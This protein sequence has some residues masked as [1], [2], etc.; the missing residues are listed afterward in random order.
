MQI[1][2]I[3]SQFEIERLIKR[4]PDFEL[5][6][7]T[8]SHKKVP[9]NY[10][11]AYAIP[12]GNKYYAWF[13]FHED[14]DVL[15]LF[16]LNKEKKITKISIIPCN[17]DSKLALGTI[18]YGVLLPDTNTFLIEDI[19]YF[20][21]IPLKHLNVSEKL[22]YIYE[23]FENGIINGVETI[24]FALPVFWVH[25]ENADFE[26]IPEEIQQTISYTVHHIQYRS[27]INIVPFL[28]V[29]LTR[30]IITDRNK[31]IEFV[32]MQEKKQNLPKMEKLIPDYNKP[33]YR[34]STVFLISAD[35][36]YDIYHLFAYGKNKSNVYY[37]VAYIPNYKTSKFMNSLFRTIKENNNLDYIEESDDEADFEDM[38]EDKYVDLQ[39]QLFI[40]CQFLPKFKRWVPK[41]VVDP[42]FKVVH[43]MNLVRNYGNF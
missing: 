43:I 27:F 20:K 3:L 7:E 26:K 21:G 8:I 24:L 28:N 4:F 29:P 2:K 32:K 9:S 22:H 36:Q 12:N 38:R 35:I 6:Y 1:D 15:Y 37:D 41:R 42:S 5:S 16:N 25:N 14:K 19:Y 23:L 39:K 18:V 11:L 17:F 31:N 33:Q 34:Q 40:E 30:K 13:S 10:N